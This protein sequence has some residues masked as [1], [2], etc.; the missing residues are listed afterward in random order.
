MFGQSGHWVSA[1]ATSGMCRI[2]DVLGVELVER[3]IRRLSVTLQAGTLLHSLSRTGLDQTYWLAETFL[4]KSRQ[5]A[6]DRRTSLRNTPRSLF[7]RT[8]QDQS[9][10][11]CNKPAIMAGNI[12]TPSKQTESWVGHWLAAPP[13]HTLNQAGR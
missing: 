4:G 13:A 2:T 8:G 5:C 9:L 6:K 10:A 7:S 3:Q 11:K 12:P 1:G